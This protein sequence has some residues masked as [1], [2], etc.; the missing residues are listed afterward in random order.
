MILTTLSKEKHFIPSLNVLLK[1]MNLNFREKKNTLP[2][3]LRFIHKKKLRDIYSLSISI[4]FFNRIFQLV[5]VIL[6]V[7]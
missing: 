5:C 3:A 2:V 1:L 4:G 6:L 7:V